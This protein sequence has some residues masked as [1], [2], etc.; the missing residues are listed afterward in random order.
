MTQDT[1]VAP[2]PTGGEVASRSGTVDM[3]TLIAIAIVAYVFA[4]V[5]HEDIGHGG[6]CL[7]TGGHPLALSTVHFE[8]GGENKLVAAG[9][10]IANCVFGILFLVMLKVVPRCLVSFRYFLWLSMTINLL[11]A[12]GYFLFSGIGNIGDWAAVIQGWHPAWAW[13]VGMTVLGIASYL[14]FI[15]LALLELT[16]F[17]GAMGPDR[18]RRAR[19]LCMVPYFSGGILSCL[20]GLFNPVGMILVAISAAAASFGGTSGLAWMWKRMRDNR[21]QSSDLQLEAPVIERSNSWIATAA[22]LAIVFVVVLGPGLK[23]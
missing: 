15:F 7:L 13:R 1:T 23:F 14:M 8:C 21:F 5:I 10:T 12:G 20:A 4:S 16:P 17:L 22:V 9:G 19:T 3:L 18:V 2:L 11:Q 6:A